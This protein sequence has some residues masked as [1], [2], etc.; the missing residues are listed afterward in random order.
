MAEQLSSDSQ[1]KL[2]PLEATSTPGFD[3]FSSGS[4]LEDASIQSQ[5]AGQDSLTNAG[6]PELTIGQT[7]L[8]EAPQNSPVRVAFVDTLERLRQGEGG[9]ISFEDPVTVLL[10]ISKALADRKPK[11]ESPELTIGQ[12]TVLPEAPQSS[13]AKTAFVDTLERLR[14]GEG[15]AISFEGSGTA[16]LGI[17][18]ALTERRL[19][20]V[21]KKHAKLKESLDA[22]KEM[23]DLFANKVKIQ[24]KSPK[25]PERIYTKHRKPNPSLVPNTFSQK[26]Q[27]IRNDKRQAKANTLYGSRQYLQKQLWGNDIGQEGFKER[28]K[29]S[30]MGFLEKQRALKAGRKFRRAQNGVMGIVGG[31]EPRKER[32]QSSAASADIPAKVINY[33]I[34]RSEKREE[35]L[36]QRLQNL[37]AAELEKQRKSR[38]KNR[39]QQS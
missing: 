31:I 26:R 9:A 14:Q 10:G 22:H 20:G 5:Y 37:E 36:Q 1:E 6:V 24:K 4:H 15:G 13:P 23:P 8:P 32:V 39:G 17:R 7:V 28:I 27:E 12:T 21:A 16:L 29:S 33:R 18:K 3:Y 25:D 38:L 30:R 35:H 2:N 11:P 34:A 19:K